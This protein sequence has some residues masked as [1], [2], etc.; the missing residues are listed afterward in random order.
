MRYSS[1]VHKIIY[2][3]DYNPEQWPKEIWREDMKLLKEAG[4]DTV[5]LNTFSWAALQPSEEE[6]DF[7]KLDEIMELAESNGLLVC[8]ATSTSAHPAWMAKNYPDILRVEFN[9][10]KRK[11]GGR[12]NSCPNSPTYR[13][14]KKENILLR[15]CWLRSCV[16]C[17]CAPGSWNLKTGFSRPRPAQADPGTG[18][19]SWE[20]CLSG[21][22]WRLTE[23]WS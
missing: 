22:I 19:C 4:V 5:T 23:L 14:N 21:S 20:G 11:F 7:G 18:R 10:M 1:K 9:G 3:G 12:H 8:L 15:C 16:P 2:G 17:F 13:G 6:Y